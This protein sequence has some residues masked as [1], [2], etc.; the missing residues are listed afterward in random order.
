[1]QQNTFWEAK[2]SSTS[3]EIP[4]IL[5]KQKVC[6]RIHKGPPRAPALSQIVSL[7]RRQTNNLFRFSEHWTQKE[8]SCMS[9][10]LVQHQHFGGT[11]WLLLRRRVLKKDK[12]D[13]CETLAS[14]CQIT[15]SHV[16]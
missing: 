12:A 16:I 3:Q 6:Y 9:H 5:W 10:H 14:L 2:S 7:E 11:C 15:R 1:M 4:C 8:C 13:F